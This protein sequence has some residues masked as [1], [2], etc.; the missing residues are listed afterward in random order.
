[1]P[2]GD[3]TALHG[4]YLSARGQLMAKGASSCSGSCQEVQEAETH[5]HS[6]SGSGS[7][8]SSTTTIASIVLQQKICQLQSVSL[9]IKQLSMRSIRQQQRILEHTRQ[10]SVISQNKAAS[11]GRHHQGESVHTAD[12]ST[13]VV[14]S[15]GI[16]D[17][18]RSI[19]HCLCAP[20]R[21]ASD[22]QQQ[23]GTVDAAVSHQNRFRGGR[24]GCVGVAAGKMHA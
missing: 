23:L 7:G 8:S 5:R 14:S 17:A 15:K 21:I 19:T 13:L 6:S 20:S 18:L 9:M 24:G 11:L 3:K 16:N 10:S 4:L 2:A 22:Q 1:M 12:A